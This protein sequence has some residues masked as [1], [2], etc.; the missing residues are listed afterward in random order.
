MSSPT[1]IAAAVRASFLQREF[2]PVAERLAEDVV[3]HSPVLARPWRTKGV[4]ARLGPAMVS[5]FDE[6][7][8]GSVVVDGARAILSFRGRLGEVEAEAIETIDLDAAGQ[9][10]ALAIYIRPLP[11]LIA[12][13]KAMEARLEP[14]L[15]A[16]HVR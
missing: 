1:A 4:I 7:E 9:I 10:S 14:E 16:E 13:A 2:S 5:I 3:F 6:I 15:V 12:V 11:A 8:F